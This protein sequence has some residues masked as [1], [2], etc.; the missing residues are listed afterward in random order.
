MDINSTRGFTFTNC[1]FT[2]DQSF[3]GN[4]CQVFF[5]G[6]NFYATNDAQMLIDSWGGQDIS[7]TNCTGQDYDDSISTDGNGWGT[8][9]FYHGDGSWGGINRGVYLGDITT[10]N[11]A[12]RIQNDNQGEQFMWECPVNNSDAPFTSPVSSA[13]ATSVTFANLTVN[14]PG[15]QVVI[16]AG[17]GLGQVRTITNCNLSTG[18]ITISQPWNVIPD[19]TSVVN[20]VAEPQD[21]AIYHNDLNGK[22]NYQTWGTSSTGVQFTEGGFDLVVDDNT[23]TD[24]DT[25][26]CD[27]PVV[28][29]GNTI[30]QPM[31][32][33]LYQNNTATNCNRAV[34]TTMGFLGGTLLDN[35]VQVLGDVYRNNSF[36]NL[37]STSI[38]W[39]IDDMYS[40]G[41]QPEFIDYYVLDDNTVSGGQIGVGLMAQPSAGSSCPIVLYKNNFSLGGGTYSGSEGLYQA[42]A[43]AALALDQN[44]WTG[45]QTTYAGIMPGAAIDLPYRV[46][47]A[48]ATSGNTAQATLPIRDAGTSALNWSLSSDVPWLTA[49]SYS[50]TV[51]NENSESDITLTALAAAYLPPGTYPA[52]VTIASGSLVQRATVY[53]TV[54]GTSSYNPTSAT[55]TVAATTPTAYEY[56]TT[57]G[58]LTFSR[59]NSTGTLCVWYGVSGTARPGWDYDQTLP[60]Y[61]VFANGQNTITQSI[62]P[63]YDKLIEA[64]ETLTAT[65]IANAAYT[66]GTSA[67]GTVTIVNDNVPTVIIV[68]I[69]S[70]ARE[71]PQTPGSLK[72]TR[73]GLG[74]LTATALT[75]YYAVGGTATPADYEETLTGAAIIPIGQT[76]TTITITPVDNWIFNQDAQTVTLTLT[77]NPSTYALGAST[78]AWVSI[79]GNNWTAQYFDVSAGLHDNRPAV[80][81]TAQQK[82]GDNW[83]YEQ[84]SGNY[85]PNF[86]PINSSTIGSLAPMTTAQNGNG[87]YYG[88]SG[89]FP[90]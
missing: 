30:T 29:S 34:T 12:D 39:Y 16:V 48:L 78:S 59:S 80:N 40:T 15:V 23:F 28:G 53:L 56:P 46:L 27:S 26:F 8:G 62:T 22:S 50:G 19:A 71:Q 52:V 45:Y 63:N 90:A 67:A 11:M 49:S 7:V 76:S 69:D 47:Y 83:W 32:W 58:V 51:N 44:T 88:Y 6:C 57:S 10:T 74:E 25:A 61:V 65:L 36:T 13:T 64:N 4:A 3:L 77:A 5:N 42:H 81:G 37:T 14:W 35:A 89:N 79:A 17:K 20:M 68:P 1:S 41:T 82:G 55:V 18:T 87:N 85:G 43:G 86:Q 9:R 66:I 31:Y 38:D 33:V 84:Y 75:V 2:E 73:S 54:T 70:D 24:L 60:G 21:I 72:I